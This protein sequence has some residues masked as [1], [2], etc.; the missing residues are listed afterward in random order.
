MAIVVMF[1]PQSVTAAQYDE[2][3]KELEKAGAAAPPG[4]TY[5]VCHG[6]SNQVQVIDVW[7]SVEK[8]QKF[9]ET[10]MPILARLG[11]NPGTPVIREVHNIIEG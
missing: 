3:I 1:T 4:R 11:I 9:G 7:D 8:F 10:L 6:P 5:T 2:C